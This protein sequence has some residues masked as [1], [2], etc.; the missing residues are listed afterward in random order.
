MSVYDDDGT[1]HPVRSTALWEAKRIHI[2]ENMQQV[3]GKLP[4]RSLKPE[5][6]VRIEGVKPF[7]NYMQQRISIRAEKEEW[8]PA[9]LL[10]PRKIRGKTAAVLCLHQTVTP[11]KAITV[12]EGKSPNDQYAHELAERGY[13][14][15]APDYPGF[16]DYTKCDPYALH[17]VST[18]MKGIWNHMRCID[19]LQ[20][21]PEVDGE[22]IGSIGHSLGG[23]NTLF[24]GVFDERV[25]AMVT[26]CGFNRFQDYYGGDLSGWSHKGYMPL[27]E[28]NYEKNP[29]KMP[30]DFTEVL[31]ALAPRAVFV[32]APVKDANF[33]VEGVV[34]CVEAAAPVFDLYGVPDN[35]QVAYPDCAHDFPPDV[36]ELA[37]AF[38][39]TRLKP[40][41]A[42]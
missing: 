33:A 42:P 30:F 35:L 40:V 34:A 16:G 32:N 36:R 10:I 26:S 17:Y 15:L 3:M 29:V 9:Y 11:G 19:V 1:L 21:L 22:R 37:Y 25:K 8:L 24:L 4:L 13:V 20:S 2:R 31:G 23:H 39:D 28:K 5:L 18:T 27:I 41:K 7:P 14:T 12:L 6:E 38:L